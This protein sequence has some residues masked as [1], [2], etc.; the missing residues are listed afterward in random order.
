MSIACS[1]PRR[2]FLRR[3]TA[4]LLLCLPVSCGKEK[5][6]AEEEAPVAPV[7]A[8]AAKKIALG[9]WT[10][11]FGTTV[12]LPNH[13]ARVSAAVEGHVLSVL[14][15]GKGTVVT[16]G[17]EVKPGQVIVQLDDRVL[18]A[19]REKLKATLTD[20]EE[21]QKQAGYAVE[22]A[23][24]DVHRLEELLGRSVPA[25]QLPPVSRI[26]LDKARVVQKEAESRQKAATAKHA[27]AIADLKA[28]DE[29]L[30]FYSLRAPIAGR[31]SL[32]QAVP[33]QTLSPGTVVADVLKL[34][35]ID[36]LCYAPPEAARRLALDQPAQLIL[37]EA[38]SAEA[39]PPL[40]GKV[41]FIAVQ[42]QPETG[43]VAVK[44]RFPNPGLRL[45]ANAVVRVNVQTQPERERLTIP[46]SAL[47]EDQEPPTVVVVQDVKT[48]KKEG[49]EHRLGKARK[50]QASVGIRDRDRHIVELLSL[51]DPANKEKVSAANL[52]FITAG[53]QGL[54]DDDAVKLEDEPKP[55]PG[56]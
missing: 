48:E 40:T 34:D 14:G 3:L 1:R 12:P 55:E 10:E 54:H 47:A 5:P 18:R 56:H 46:E 8:E 28:L 31:L 38:P 33:G 11:L 29:Q 51:E 2:L 20:L 24:I 30:E 13:S 52:L 42:A 4:G 39:K 36:V 53:G 19:N 45:G 17:Q 21:Q 6:H 50:L 25:G 9:E 37:V 15:D 44:V 27:V 23:L 32:V 22:L 16:E 35:L 49:E 26:E 43:N 7:H 41:A